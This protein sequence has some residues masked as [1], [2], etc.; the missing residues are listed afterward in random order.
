MGGDDP[1][2]KTHKQLVAPVFAVEPGLS[3]I[4]HAQAKSQ[5]HAEALD[6]WNTN[7]SSKRH[8][9]KQWKSTVLEENGEKSGFPVCQG[10]QPT[11]KDDDD[12]DD[13]EKGDDSGPVT[14]LWRFINPEQLR[15]ILQL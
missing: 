3:S 1:A 2:A 11:D 13:D 15:Q 14:I 8:G 9:I 5:Q 12:D 6:F 7:D 4:E 10:S